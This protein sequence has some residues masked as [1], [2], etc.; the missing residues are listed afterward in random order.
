[1][2][3][4]PSESVRVPVCAR[5][6]TYLLICTRFVL[7]LIPCTKLDFGTT[8]ATVAVDNTNNIIRAGRNAG[9]SSRKKN[10]ESEREIEESNPARTHLENF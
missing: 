1:M 3:M 6:R 10:E 4:R 5:A 7:S 9:R 2:K 8:Y